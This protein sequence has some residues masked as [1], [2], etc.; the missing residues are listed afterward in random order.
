MCDW[1]SM[2][3]TSRICFKPVWVYIDLY[4]CTKIIEAIGWATWP[5]GQP[6]V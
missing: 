5:N 2:M 1:S 3:L 6:C 4:D